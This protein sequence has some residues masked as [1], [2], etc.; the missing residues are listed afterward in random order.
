MSI[1]ISRGFSS[2]GLI[3]ALSIGSL[4]TLGYVNFSHYLIA[5]NA[6]EQA[7]RAGVRCVSPTDAECGGLDSS[8]LVPNWDYIETLQTPIGDT[9]A[10]EYDYSAQMFQ[11]IF[12][13]QSTYYSFQR[14]APSLVEFTTYT[15]PVSR[16]VTT[17]SYKQVELNFGYTGNRDVSVATPLPFPTLNQGF[18]K[19]HDITSFKLWQSDK[20]LPELE[21]EARSRF[22][23]V[24]NRS[25]DLRISGTESERDGANFLRRTTLSR[26]RPFPV[27]TLIGE[28]PS[29]EKC[30]TGSQ[31][32]A[33]YESGGPMSENPNQYRSTR[34]L[35]FYVEVKIDGHSGNPL[36]GI[37]KQEDSGFNVRINDR[38]FCLGGRNYTPLS[39]LKG[40]FFN[41]WLRGVKGSS[42]GDGEA[43]CRDG[44]YKL[45]RFAVSPDGTF[46]PEVGLVVSGDVGESVRGELNVYALVD[47]YDDKIESEVQTVSCPK[48]LLEKGVTAESLKPAPEACGLDPKITNFTTQF[49][50]AEKTVGC[51]TASPSNSNTF[52]P[53][54][55]PITNP[56]TLPVAESAPEVKELVMAEC[57]SNSV[58]PASSCP[59]KKIPTG[60][61]R[62]EIGSISRNSCPRALPKKD[63]LQCEP[64]ESEVLSC[65]AEIRN[66]SSCS[67][68]KTKRLELQ[69]LN[70]KDIYALPLDASFIPSEILIRGAALP[71]RAECQQIIRSDNL[72]ACG[73]EKT[74]KI[75]S[76]PLFV[77][78]DLSWKPLSKE[79]YEESSEINVPVCDVT[80]PARVAAASPARAV[81]ITG[82]PFDG[83]TQLEIS[84]QIPELREGKIS[85]RQ[86]DSDQSLEQVLRSYA[87]IQGQPEAANLDLRFSYSATPLGTARL[88]SST[89]A[90]QTVSSSIA[91]GC[92]VLRT[93]NSGFESCGEI[94]LGTFSTS[95]QRCKVPGV[96]CRK[97][98]SSIQSEVDPTPQ[99]VEQ[100][101]VKAEEL[102]R[103][104]LSK[105]LPNAGLECREASCI[106]VEVKLLPEKT[107]SVLAR[108]RMPLTW[109]LNE[110]LGKQSIELQRERKERIESL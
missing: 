96:T 5:E 59:W 2:L 82:Y 9:Y 11:Q 1:K 22:Q 87:S 99:L 56:L 46:T 54:S 43:S 13:A 100:S 109:P 79:F 47:K 18:E 95:P 17:E 80:S 74:A 26:S 33:E 20:T 52:F 49:F 108:Y 8:A 45:D 72:A 91:E 16:Y 57:G 101:R 103:N 86:P 66:S 83:T 55:V 61:E 62:I 69:A 70:Y 36:L 98:P 3:G 77:R 7:T 68:A 41:L 102:T 35:A 10:N 42:G 76:K 106:Q 75:I 31:C 92:P 107:V 19:D 23:L 93:L 29:T 44:Q 73:V 39:S 37:K 53:S 63:K 48:V 30:A 25:F 78:S 60:E 21:V 94:N 51:L 32:S 88:V 28:E 65:N 104:I 58:L 12:E 38:K 24:L 97:V 6:L 34:Y 90:C 105:F 27:R 110:L 50:Y 4:I 89:L 71:E 40:G 64:G 14:E 84:S 67:A 85:C 81:E 15:V